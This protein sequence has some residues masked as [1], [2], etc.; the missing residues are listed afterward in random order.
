MFEVEKQ[1]HLFRIS[2]IYCVEEQQYVSQPHQETK[3]HAAKG[4][5]EEQSWSQEKKEEGGRKR[6]QKAKAMCVTTIQSVG[7]EVEAV[8][9]KQKN[10]TEQNKGLTSNSRLILFNAMIGSWD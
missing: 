1:Y 3:A 7:V 5:E 9:N 4:K 2:M 8:K 10:I 6:M